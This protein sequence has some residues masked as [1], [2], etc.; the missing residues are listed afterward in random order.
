MILYIQVEEVCKRI[1]K[2]GEL[3][4]KKTKYLTQKEKQFLS[5]E[6][7]A[8]DRLLYLLKEKIEKR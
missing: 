5:G 7:Y 6:E 1:K 2:E 3:Y 8:L 4:R